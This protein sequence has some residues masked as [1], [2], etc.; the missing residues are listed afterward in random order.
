M[1]KMSL[2]NFNS[3]QPTGTYYINLLSRLKDL[4]CDITI[5]FEK[6]CLFGLF[7]FERFGSISFTS[8]GLKYYR[9]HDLFLFKSNIVSSMVS[10]FCCIEMPLQRT[11]LLSQ[12]KCK[13]LP[14]C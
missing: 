7:L 2:S 1:F 3:L 8:N 13:S 4:I 9:N 11:S 6:Q 10:V 5:F 14:D 12:D